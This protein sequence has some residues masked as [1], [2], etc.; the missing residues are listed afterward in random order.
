VQRRINAAWV[1]VRRYFFVGGLGGMS[2][3]IAFGALLFYYLEVART[4][5]WVA[6]IASVL[7]AVLLILDLGRPHLFINMLRVFKPQSAMSMGAWI[8]AAF[9]MCVVLG[10]IA[11]EL[12]T[13]HLFAGAIDQI[14]GVAAGI[15]IFGS[16]LA[17]SLGLRWKKFPV[18]IRNRFLL[19]RSN[20]SSLSRLTSISELQNHAL[21]MR[22]NVEGRRAQKTYER[23]VAVA[24]ELDRKT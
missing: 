22:V 20:T 21:D 8:L 2:A 19:R 9:R 3:V 10:L 16:A 15:L 23:L 1:R 18:G 11:L 24:R 12:Q 17:A 13:F 7:S 4:A 5:M 6:A 14:L